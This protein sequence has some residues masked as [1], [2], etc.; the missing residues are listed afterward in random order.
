MSGVKKCKWYKYKRIE[1]LQF[2]QVSSGQKKTL[3]SGV[4]KYFHRKNHSENISIFLCPSISLWKTIIFF[5]LSGKNIFLSV[6]KNISGF[7]QLRKNFLSLSRKIA[8]SFCREKLSVS[9]IEKRTF[10]HSEKTASLSV[11]KNVL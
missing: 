5:C 4:T 2:L 1:E 9:H 3:S 11:R 10:S 6:R 7:F 8:I